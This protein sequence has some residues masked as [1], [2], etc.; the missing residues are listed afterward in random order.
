MR[1]R[2]L[3]R[4]VL[5]A[6]ATAAMLTVAACS[7]VPSDGPINTGLSNLRQTDQFVQFDPSGPVPG[8]TQEDVIRGFVSA[9]SSTANDYAVAREF[10]TRNYATQWEP[11]SGVMIDDSS[12]PFKQS[13]E[14]IGVLSVSLVATVDEQGVLTAVT[15]GPTTELRFELE[16]EGSEW[17]I[18][19]APAGVVLDRN[20]FTAVWSPHPLYFPTVSGTMVADNRWYPSRTNV[21]T[22]IVQGLIDGPSTVLENVADT[23]FPANSEISGGGVD[24]NEG[25]VKVDL[26]DAVGSLAGPTLESIGAQLSYSLQSVTTVSDY[27]LSVEGVEVKS[28]VAEAYVSDLAENRPPV[29][30]V[31]DRLGVVDSSGVSSAMPLSEQVAEIPAHSI[32]L[33][34]D[35]MEAV[36]HTPSGA[37]VVSADTDLVVDGR[38]NIVGVSVDPSGYVWSAVSDPRGEVRATLPGTTEQNLEPLAPELERLNGIRVSPDGNWMAY[39]VPVD[40]G[41]EVRVASIIRDEEGTPTGFSESTLTV[42]WTSGSPR[43]F[44]WVGDSRIALLTEVGKAGK[45]TIG[46]VGGF[47]ID[48]GSVPDAVSITGTS[49]RG[50]VRILTS[51]GELMAPQGVSGWQEV[52]DG[53]KTLARWG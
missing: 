15:P 51:N 22:K 53:V 10:L 31:D 9:A 5:A 34:D 13:G 46:T 42:L 33:S 49:S 40:D 12:R 11:T 41:T 1:T 48:R 38:K 35:A 26:T 4:T 18:S 7:T 23:S 3:F 52:L 19:S 28:D 20:T 29:A 44:D 14:N 21:A 45:V 36:L 37:R 43:D 8:S 39:M 17:R 6:A 24:T 47:T 50:Q 30:L 16:R 2:T 25:T 32:S 27:T